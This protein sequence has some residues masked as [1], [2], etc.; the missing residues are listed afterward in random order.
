MADAEPVIEAP[1]SRRLLARSEPKQPAAAPPKLVQWAREPVQYY[2]GSTLILSCSLATSLAPGAALKFAWFKQGR[3]LLTAPS[4]AAASSA[5]S[6]SLSGRVS[7][8]TLADYSILRLAQLRPSDSGA[9]TCVASNSQGQED[10]T[11]AQI[12]VN[13]E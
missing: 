9:Y 13:G 12:V 5:V 10:R 4:A 8:E 6:N 2:E 11:T 1:A 7:V 3:P